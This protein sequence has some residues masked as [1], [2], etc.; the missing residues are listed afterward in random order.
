VDRREYV[1]GDP[2]TQWVSESHVTTDT[3]GSEGKIELLG[4][5][6]VPKQYYSSVQAAC[7]DIVGRFE[8]VFLLRYKLKLIAT[9]KDTGLSLSH[10]PMV[11]SCRCTQTTQ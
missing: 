7:D 9:K 5:V 8:K 2:L 10:Y 3:V 11:Q 6:H 4:M 1:S